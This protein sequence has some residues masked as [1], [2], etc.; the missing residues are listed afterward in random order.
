MQNKKFTPVMEYIKNRPESRS[1]SKSAKFQ[2]QTYKK[3]DLVFS[4][5]ARGYAAYIIRTGGVEISVRGDGKKLVIAT[6]GEESVFGVM[7]L[8]LGNH[9]RTVTATAIEDSQVIR[10]P[11]KIF[12]TYMKESPK[13]ISSCL[14]AI[15]RRLHEITADTSNRPETLESIARILDLLHI[16]DRTELFYS[17]TI[18]AIAGILLKEEEEI[19]TDLTIMETFSLVEIKKDNSGEKMITL[20][21]GNKFLEKSLKLFKILGE[22]GYDDTP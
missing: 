8:I 9:V 1:I 4:K 6:L 17:K 12:D 2:I 7:A 20:M 14:V 16:H 18:T 3:G 11:K 19:I 22:H 15:A 5:G 21:G 13:V 10:I